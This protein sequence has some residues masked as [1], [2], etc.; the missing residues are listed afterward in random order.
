MTQINLPP[1]LSA[2]FTHLPLSK[3]NVY[4]CNMGKEHI[5]VLVMHFQFEEN[6]KL[7][8]QIPNAIEIRRHALHPYIKQVLR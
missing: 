1:N 6:L 8:R 7:Y 4:S 3:F 5:D 2:R